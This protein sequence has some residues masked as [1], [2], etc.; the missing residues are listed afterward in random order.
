[1]ATTNIVSLITQFITPE[2]LG[3]IAA[4]LGTDRA[5]VQKA[6][7]AGVPGI[8]AA[9]TSALAKPGGAA[10]IENAVAQQDPGGLAD[11]SRMVGTPQQENVV[12]QG[13]NSLSSLLGGSTTNVLTTALGKYAGLGNTGAKGLVGLL[14]PLV[15][16]VLG[17]HQAAQG[18]GAS[19]V[20]NLLKSQADNI[21]RAMPSGFANA[22]KGT[23]ILDQLPS[24]AA[25]TPTAQLPPRRAATGNWV[26]P[27]LAALALFGFGWYMLTRGGPDTATDTTQT[28]AQTPSPSD[29]RFT[30]AEQ[31]VGNWI[32]KPVYSSDNQKVGE[33]VELKRGPNDDVTDV[34]MDTESFLGIGGHR[35][36]VSADQIREV[37][38]DGLVLTLTEADVKAM[39]STA[40]P[41]SSASP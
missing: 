34:Y 19:G 32:H 26:L 17:Q 13:F 11:L 14:G 36:H 23:G 39:S 27:V 5:L 41:P 37:K 18:G 12:K 15:M 9:L 31:D 3:R 28:Q 4:A 29:S 35:Y 2:M 6:I 22:L 8:L 16:G 38:P 21:A 30:V 33:I 10:K 24:A 40:T 25:M 20:A 7:A 1:M